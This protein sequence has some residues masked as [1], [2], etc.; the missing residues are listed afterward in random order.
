M[1]NK[2]VHAGIVNPQELDTLSQHTENAGLKLV[3]LDGTFVLPTSEEDVH[4]N[5]QDKRLPGAVFFDIKAIKDT[6]SDLPHMLP[7]AETF[8]NAVSALGINN[9]DIIVVY[10]QHG[11]TMGP[12][13]VWWMF[14]GFGHDNVIVLNGGLPAWEKAG[15]ETESGSTSPIRPSEYQAKPFQQNMVTAMHDVL[16]ACNENICPIIDARPANRFSG[17]S[18]EPRAGMRSGHMPQAMNLPASSIVD[19]NG[20]MRSADEII[21]LFEG[22]GL[23]LTE[24]KPV[25]TTCGS[26]ITACVLALALHHLGHN[27]VA[28]YDGSWSEWGLETSQT[29]VT[30]S[31]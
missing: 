28:V 19:E 24:N 25:I 16:Q 1:I 22:C 29:P 6:S 31:T 12:A 8:S 2:F 11:M 15:L 4:Q 23:K 21:S 17:E 14:K 5:Y 26:G 3:F 18:P 13:R 20:M 9:A 30:T 7:N 27:D 10:G